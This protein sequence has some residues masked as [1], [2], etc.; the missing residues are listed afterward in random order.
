MLFIQSGVKNLTL[1][2]R[3]VAQ[4]DKFTGY[5]VG[6]LNFHDVSDETLDSVVTYSCS[7]FSN[8]KPRK[9]YKA[10]VLLPSKFKQSYESQGNYIYFVMPT[11]VNNDGEI[12][13]SVIC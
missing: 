8:L 9:T 4:N 3:K 2:K 13:G 6:E 12:H 7:N 11:Y 5:A 1:E 10:K